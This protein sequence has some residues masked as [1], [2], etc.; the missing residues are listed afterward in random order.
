MTNEQDFEPLL[1]TQQAQL[2]T[3]IADGTGIDA[4]TLAVAAINVAILLFIA[5]ASLHVH[6][7]W[8]HVFLV[9]P[10]ILSL[11]CNARGLFPK[12]YLGLSIDLQ[13]HPE[14]LE[15]AKDDLLLQLLSDT[16][17]AIDHNDKVNARYWHYCE[18]SMALTIIATLTLFAILRS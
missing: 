12:R 13:K 10:L 2:N 1:T 17:H 11:L 7:W 3:V 6:T 18:A 8:Q 5:Q 9:P 15:M 4:K 14:Y 16:M